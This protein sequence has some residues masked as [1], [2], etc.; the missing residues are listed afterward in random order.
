MI[1][2]VM[3]SRGEAH[4]LAATLAALV[5]AAAEGFVSQVIIADVDG[6]DTTRRVADAMGC[7]LREGTREEACRAAK[8]EWILLIAPG[9]RLERDWFREAALFIERAGR[10]GGQRNAASFR[11]AVDDF[12]LRARL[13]E[14]WTRLR[15]RLLP[16]KILLAPKA[17]LA[18]GRRLRT[19]RLRARA[20]VGGLARG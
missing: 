11:H 14:V 4:E 8:A 12:G 7:D 20:Y 9:V 1:S 10:T 16:P 17:A 6:R 13:G 18:D 2:V 15:S 3:E 19:A 5:P